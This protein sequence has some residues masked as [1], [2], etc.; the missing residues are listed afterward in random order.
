M[1]VKFIIC[2][3]LY[4]NFNAKFKKNMILFV[5]LPRIR[6]GTKKIGTY[7]NKRYKEDRKRDYS[8]GVKYKTTRYKQVFT[9]ACFQLIYFG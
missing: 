7:N 4:I 9:D 8:L 1:L 3:T 5:H 6:A 2:S